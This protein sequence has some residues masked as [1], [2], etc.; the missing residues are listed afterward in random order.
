MKNPSKI[1]MEFHI[2]Q[3]GDTPRVFNWTAGQPANTNSTV[4]E[5]LSPN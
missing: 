2:Y 5:G 3:L 4:G 1:Y